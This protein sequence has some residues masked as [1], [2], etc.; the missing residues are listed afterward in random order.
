MTDATA[1][2]MSG[3]MRAHH[4]DLLAAFQR[5]SDAAAAAPDAALDIAYGP[6]PR[7]TFDFFAGPGERRGTLAFFHAG[8]WQSRDKSQFRFLAPALLARGFDVAM[9]NYPLCPDVDLAALVEAAREAVPAI[10]ARAGGSRL[11]AAGHSAGAHIAVEL[12]LTDWRA[13]GLDASPI[14]AVVALS[15]V[16]DLEPLRST[17]LNDRLRLDE[18]AARANS[19]IHRVVWGMPPALFAVGGGETDAFR[20]QNAAMHA[21]WTA[22]GNSGAVMEIAAA[23]H[24]TLLRKLQGA[25]ELMAAVEALTE[26]YAAA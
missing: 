12:A 21:A 6:H 14:A 26:P 10:R 11:M 7:E 13:R 24:F 25:S 22:A 20:A 8:Y 16:F 15:G 1:Q 5:E 2:Y 18:D 3:Q 9:V 19:P 4:P 17:P 23:D